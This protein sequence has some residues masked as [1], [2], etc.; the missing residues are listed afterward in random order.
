MSAFSAGSAFSA[1]SIL[2][3]TA[4]NA[5]F[6]NIETWL[7]T[8][9]A[10]FDNTNTFTGATTFSAGVTTSAGIT[11]NTTGITIAP[12]TAI[13][14]SHA[15]ARVIPGATSL[16]FRNNANSAD[17]LSIADAGTVTFRG[18]AVFAGTL[19]GITN[20]T[21]SG[22]ISG[23]T[24]IDGTT[25]TGSTAVAAAKFTCTAA[26]TKFMLGATNTLFRK[27]DDSATAA[28]M[29]A[30]AFGLSTGVTFSAPVSMGAGLVVGTDVALNAA[31]I[32]TNSTTGFAVIPTCAG[33]PT[34]SLGYAGNG[35]PIIYDTTAH[36][37]WAN[38]GGTTWKSVTLS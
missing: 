20:I 21:L 24:T 16:T 12:Q 28:T 17:N 5:R 29:S 19:T 38:E 3:S 22:T 7:G 35:A 2:T 14:F 4:L 10:Y 32:A 30:T 15:S 31:A 9:A 8:Y 18:A 34:G 33:T 25:I 27:S 37:L 11:V 26:S 36:K 1:N 23:G 6:S 13:T